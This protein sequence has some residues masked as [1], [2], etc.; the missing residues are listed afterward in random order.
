M[1]SVWS[2]LESGALPAPRT[3]GPLTRTDV[4]RYQGASGDFNPI[5]HDEPFAT[6]SGY[7]APLGIGML[8]AG[9]LFAWASDW[10]GPANVRR[11]RCRWKDMVFPGDTLTLSG[12]VARLYEEN[13]ER[14]VDLEL[15]CSKQGGGVAVQAWATFVVPA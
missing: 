8:P 9:A 15:V 12:T 2:Q 7:P 3:L 11:A 14:R 4:V 6:A 5:H 13:G 10:L 1:T